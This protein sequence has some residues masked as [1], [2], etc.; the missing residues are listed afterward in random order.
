[1]FVRSVMYEDNCLIGRYCP[2]M[3]ASAS[4]ARCV[5]QTFCFK[6]QWTGGE[7][8]ASGWSEEP[9]PQPADEEDHCDVT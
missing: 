8:C 9:T 6:P 2:T 5:L 4:L 1:M 3:M 7:S